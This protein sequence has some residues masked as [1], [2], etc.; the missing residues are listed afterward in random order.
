MTKQSS[1]PRRLLRVGPASEYMSMSAA[2]LRALVQR[3]ELPVIKD[4]GRGP[5]L[6]DVRD[7]DL[8]VERQKHTL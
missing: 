4:G 6:V 1:P 8:W 5:W 3:G 2:K 7:L